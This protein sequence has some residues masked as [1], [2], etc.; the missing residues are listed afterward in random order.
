MRD[1]PHIAAVLSACGSAE[2][3]GEVLV[4]RVQA[5]RYRPATEIGGAWLERRQTV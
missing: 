3:L 1:E 4:A 2:A 5:V